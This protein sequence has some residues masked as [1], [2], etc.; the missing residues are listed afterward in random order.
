MHSAFSICAA[1]LLA[2]PL[3]AAEDYAA[4]AHRAKLRMNTTASGADVSGDVAGFPVLVRLTGAGFAFSEAAP[5]GR[6]IRFS[7]SA[8]QPLPYQIERWH[9]AAKVAEIWVKVDL[10]PG[11]SDKAFFRMH[12]GKASAA[13]SSKG[14]AVFGASNGFAA[15]WHLG[16]TGD[17]PNAVAGG[18]PAQPRNYNGEESVPGLIGLADS[19]EGFKD[20]APGGYLDL[21]DGYG[22]FAEGFTFTAW[23]HSSAKNWYSHILDLGNGKTADNIVLQRLE[24]TQT[25]AFDVYA[26]TLK[27]NS[28]H[29]ES[30]LVQDRWQHCAVTVQGKSFKY[31]ADGVLF[32]ADTLS[33]PI[34]GVFRT[35]NFL[36]KS[37]WPGDEYFQ[38]VYDEVGLATVARGADW[39]KLSHANQVRSQRFVTVVPESGCS[40][41]LEVAGDTSMAEGGLLSLA[42]LAE[43]AV[44]HEWSALE[45]PAPRILD[46]EAETLLVRLPRVDRDTAIRY[47][48]S[49]DFEDSTASRSVLVFI[50]NS[51]PDP[52]FTLPGQPYWNG[53]DPFPLRPSIQNLSAI[54]ASA[55]PDLHYAWSAGGWNSGVAE[56]DWDGMRADL[57]EYGQ[58]DLTLCL[59]NGG[60]AVCRSTTVKLGAT[61]GT[62]GAPVTPGW[63]RADGS[64]SAR[65][66][67]PQG[68]RKA[69]DPLGR[70][71]A[72]PGGP[73]PA[74]NL[75][76]PASAP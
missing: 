60:P 54:L 65:S 39:I 16:G 3:R 62:V 67:A 38:G 25:A 43:C 55:A 7:N 4:W 26:D 68:I 9:A 72:P 58:V 36:G 42:G 29:V 19:L 63:D 57:I 23:I 47:L 59:D 50:R 33:V 27:S 10:V 2:Y 41:R 20:G 5:D 76:I 61:T 14:S 45:G 44:R 11:N 13:D 28:V 30:V 31:Y 22:G 46:P 51:I 37:N 75:F 56:P 64:G 34:S 6:D 48:F 15:A 49:V 1:V 32:H 69:F 12:W 53:S 18:N 24:T 71:V 74:G 52:V 73:R 70:R 21:G 35:E 17:R 8:G 66:P 40:P